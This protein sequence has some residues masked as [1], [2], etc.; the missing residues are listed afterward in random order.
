MNEFP[1]L[2]HSSFTTGALPVRGCLLS[3]NQACVGYFLFNDFLSE[4]KSPSS[5]SSAAFARHR[6]MPPPPF[7]VVVVVVL[8]RSTPHATRGDSH[9]VLDLP[10]RSPQVKGQGHR[11]DD[12]HQ[13]QERQ[14][15]L[16]EACT[17]G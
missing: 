1:S 17:A 5:V 7:F 3:T 14:P 2:G 12:A 15:G 16:Q 6:V 8:K 4:E 11:E 9:C 13:H 10:R